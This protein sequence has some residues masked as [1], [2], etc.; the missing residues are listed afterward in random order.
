MLYLKQLIE[1]QIFDRFVQSSC[2]M[3]PNF[4]EPIIV[5]ICKH[6]KPISDLLLEEQGVQ[7]FPLSSFSL[8]ILAR[9]TS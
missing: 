4:I 3:N 2:H 7:C 5:C 8:V 9:S 1:K 6:C